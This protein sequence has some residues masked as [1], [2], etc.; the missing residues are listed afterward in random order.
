[1]IVALDR[2]IEDMIVDYTEKINLKN[3]LSILEKSFLGKIQS[4]FC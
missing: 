2:K 4:E 1:V 3:K